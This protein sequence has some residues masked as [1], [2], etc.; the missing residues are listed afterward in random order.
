MRISISSLIGLS[1]LLFFAACNNTS[2]NRLS[3]LNSC[4]ESSPTTD[5]ASF[6]F[7]EEQA[8][9]FSAID[10]SDFPD[11]KAIV[12]QSVITT[13]DVIRANEE[14]ATFTI[15]NSNMRGN[16]TAMAITC[17]RNLDLDAVP[18]SVTFN[19]PVNNQDGALSYQVSTLSFGNPKQED[20]S[21]FLTLTTEAF[22]PPES[23]SDEEEQA[24]EPTA[25]TKEKASPVAFSTFFE[26]E[27]GEIAVYR[28]KDD[29]NKDK[30]DSELETYQIHYKNDAKCIR[31]RMVVRVVNEDKK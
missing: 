14:K 13:I 7:S 28:V 27:G 8:K 21:D 20:M 15:S 9:V 22:L 31:S 4:K 1:F 30:K 3:A 16:P 26:Q 19:T 17:A 6:S 10:E 18:T 23:E 5:P 24:T 25:D 11:S 2:N 12:V 29:K